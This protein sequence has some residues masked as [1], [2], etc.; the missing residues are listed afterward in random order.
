[1]SL[2]P[3]VP[4]LGLARV[5]LLVVIPDGQEPTKEDLEPIANLTGLEGLA[6]QNGY[7]PPEWLSNTAEVKYLNIG[8]MPND[9]DFTPWAKLAPKTEELLVRIGQTSLWEPESLVGFAN[10]RSITFAGAITNQGVTLGG[11]SKE[12]VAL[13]MQTAQTLPWVETINRLPAKDITVEALGAVD[14]P[15]R[16]DI[17]PGMEQAEQEARINAAASALTNWALGSMAAGD[18]KG[19]G[20]ATISTPALE[21]SHPDASESIA[22][23]C[24]LINL[25]TSQV[26]QD[27]ASC[28]TI[29]LVELVVGEEK[30]SYVRELDAN[31]NVAFKGHTGITQVTVYHLKDRTKY[32]PFQIAV[33]DPPK[34][35]TSEQA[36]IGGM[37]VEAYRSWIKSH[38]Q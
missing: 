8:D 11:Y 37:D 4:Q 19:G 38:L 16:A 9:F 5:D 7:V 15:N 26:C 21:C 32:G 34:S 2:L 27:E 35:A 33:T 31:Q 29:F 28:S 6:F 3:V 30:G 14:A 10:L 36:A 17:L 25:E 24:G 23:T 18:W 22:T 13:V 12:T 1:L 20:E